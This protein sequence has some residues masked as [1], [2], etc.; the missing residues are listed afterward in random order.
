MF[1]GKFFG[2]VDHR[3]MQI[4]VDDRVYESTNV[5]DY[6][7]VCYEDR[8]VDY[9]AIMKRNSALRAMLFNPFKYLFAA[10]LSLVSTA[11]AV[12]A[13]MANSKCRKFNASS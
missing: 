8:M 1:T 13:Y 3:I 5:Y 10:L 9:D 12:P 2:S 4:L 7:A 11:L 6:Q